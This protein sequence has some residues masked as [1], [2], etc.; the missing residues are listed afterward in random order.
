MEDT[1]KAALEKLEIPSRK[2]PFSRDQLLEAYHRAE[3]T[4]K[5]EAQHDPDPWLA[6]NEKQLQLNLRNYIFHLG[7]SGQ[8]AFVRLV[9]GLQAVP[10]AN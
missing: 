6:H 1:F 7:K 3:Q 8:A 5:R 4:A 9:Q 10:P 2:C